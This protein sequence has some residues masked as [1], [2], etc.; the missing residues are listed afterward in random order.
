METVW[1]LD[2]GTTSIG[3]SV[4]RMDIKKEQGEIIKTG[5][6]IFPEGLNNDHEPRNKRRRDMRLHRRQLRRR[7]IR[8][9]ELSRKFMEMDH[10]SCKFI[11]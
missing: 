5:V 6:R 1:G 7:R 4:V 3:F 9:I 2:L 10:F 11:R 8:R